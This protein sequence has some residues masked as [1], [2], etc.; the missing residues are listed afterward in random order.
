[1]NQKETMTRYVSFAVV[2]MTFFGIALHDTKL[3]TMTKFAMA[4][5]A[6]IAAYEGA[7]LLHALG[8]DSHTHVERV[9]GKDLARKHTSSMPRTQARRDDE[10]KY[11][12]NGSEPKGRNAFDNYYLPLTA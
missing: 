5:P 3:D 12:H 8:G 10:K 9:S 11:R 2:I 6:V 4:L 1:M 7:Q